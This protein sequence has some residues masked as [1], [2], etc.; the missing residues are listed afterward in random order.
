MADPAVARDNPTM[1]LLER[2][3][4][5]ASRAEYA[6]LA[7]AGQGRLVQF[8]DRRGLSSEQIRG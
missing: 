3:H 5:L 6:Q 4:I 2:D 1:R 8:T 7:R